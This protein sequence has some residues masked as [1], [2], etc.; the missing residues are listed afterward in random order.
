[1][2]KPDRAHHCKVCDICIFRMDHH[3]PWV[4]N[5]VG[6]RNQRLF[7]L[8]LIYIALLSI[9]S[10]C[11]ELYVLFVYFTQGLPPDPVTGV[12]PHATS[13]TDE[14]SYSN[15]ALFLGLALT[16]QS[17]FFLFFVGDF[18]FEQIEAIETNSTLVETYQKKRGRKMGMMEHMKEVMGPSLALWWIPFANP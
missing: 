3:C 18:F 10:L 8:F 16:G 4:N 5:C 11:L 6:F 14:Y 13:S 9:Y 2:G 12:R 17:G 1:M 15:L 7:I